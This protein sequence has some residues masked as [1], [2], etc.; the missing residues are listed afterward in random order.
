MIK[1]F[2]DE[3]PIIIFLGL[4]LI[5]I[6]AIFTYSIWNRGSYEVISNLPKKYEIIGIKRPKHFQLDLK[7]VETG[8]LYD[9]VS[10]SKHCNNWR[11]IPLNSIYT[12]NEIKYKYS[13]ENIIYTKVKVD[14]NFCHHFN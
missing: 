13:K 2:D 1:K 11:K 3:D 6:F 10:V 8:T 14:S 5:I 9:K 4:F 7:E 12:F